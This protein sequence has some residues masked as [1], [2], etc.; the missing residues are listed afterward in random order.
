[1][2]DLSL[3]SNLIDEEVDPSTQYT[4][5]NQENGTTD[6]HYLD[7]TSERSKKYRDI[8]VDVA[9]E[10][11][12]LKIDFF[13]KIYSNYNSL[14]LDK[15][16]LQQE[17][18]RSLFIELAELCLDIKNYK[19]LETDDQ[20]IQIY[21]ELSNGYS[22]LIVDEYGGLTYLVMKQK[23]A[24]Y[25]CDYYKNEN[26]DNHVKKNVVKMFSLL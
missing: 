12:N 22:S 1:M 15:T 23:G 21:K 25:I 4:S 7:D 16:E 13:S 8:A 20:E 19:I 14:S 5:V 10:I 26:I 6:E 24:G 2:N 17:V 3:E 9:E 18:S 11:V